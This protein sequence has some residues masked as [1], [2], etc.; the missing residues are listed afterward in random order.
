[1]PAL[2]MAQDSGRLLAWRKREGETVRK[3]EPLMDIETDK[4]VVEVEAEADGILVGVQAREG[5][6]VPV[7]RTIAW[8]VA[9]GEPIPSNPAAAISAPATAAAFAT[10]APSP[11]S[12]TASDAPTALERPR[13]SPKARRLA[14]ERGVD[15]RAVASTAGPGPVRAADVAAASSS[16]SL[17]ERTETPDG[18]WRAMAER[19]TA[20]WTSVPQFFVVRDVDA[21]A[22]VAWRT[23]L[24]E[25]ADGAQDPT[26]TYSDLLV[27]AVARALRRYPRLNASWIE[28]RIVY[29]TRINI[30]LA[31]AVERGL[32]VP[33]VHDADRLSVR[34]IARL[35]QDLVERARTN[36]LRPADLAGGTFT[37]SNLGPQGVHAF[38]AIVNAPQ[39][40]ILAV[41]QIA[42]RPAVRAGQ[43]VVRPQVTLTLG[44]DHRIVD[45]ARAA[46]FLQ[47]VA[48]R[49]EQP[50]RDDHDPA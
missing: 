24:L 25:A 7:G 13:A 16:E 38:T 20:A 30:G 33:V 47:D 17:E 35:R 1:M 15:L 12:A 10:P 27:A 21:T 29:H 32:V 28:G 50:E 49:L 8:I 14:A 4:A 41:G 46:G 42:D 34:A 3:G 31:T 5:D 48:E 43:L 2:E 36:R 11:V 26:V 9:P 45:G 22:L 23:R 37:V 44:C 18:L 19:V 6:V 40:A 39:A